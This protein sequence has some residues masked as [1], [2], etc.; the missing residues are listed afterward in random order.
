[1]NNKS[2]FHDTIKELSQPD[3]MFIP[4]SDRKKCAYY[5]NILLSNRL[6]IFKS[7]VNLNSHKYTY[8]YRKI[9]VCFRI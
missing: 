4:G 3:P 8:K 7:V 9:N 6:A 2:S 1:M 5:K